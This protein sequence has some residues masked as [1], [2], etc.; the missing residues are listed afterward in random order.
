MSAYVD[1]LVFRGRKTRV[2]LERSERFGILADSLH[3]ET[4]PWI[5]F[6]ERVTV[7]HLR[8]LRDG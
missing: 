6:S 2:A 8:G 7:F 4:F 1:F 5:A 3:C